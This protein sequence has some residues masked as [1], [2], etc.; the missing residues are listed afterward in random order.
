MAIIDNTVLYDWN[1]LGVAKKINM[2]GDG[3]VI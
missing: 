1:L 2:W 3:C